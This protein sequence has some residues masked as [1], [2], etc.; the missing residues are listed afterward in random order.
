M[1]T[2]I[3][4]TFIVIIFTLLI[5]FVSLMKCIFKTLGLCLWEPVEL[6]LAIFTTICAVLGLILVFRGLIGYLIEWDILIINLT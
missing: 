5:F 1:K 6:V 3:L 2:F 4:I